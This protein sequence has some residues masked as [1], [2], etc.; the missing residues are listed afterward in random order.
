[1]ATKNSSSIV[2]RVLVVG[3]GPGG[4][5]AAISLKQSGIKEV[6]LADASSEGGILGSELMMQNPALRALERLGVAQ[7]CVEVGA[8]LDNYYFFDAM[9]NPIGEEATPPVVTGPHLPSLLG[10]SRP[11]IHKVL[12]DRARAL[13]CEIRYDQKLVGIAQDEHRVTAMFEN[14]EQGT[15]DLLVGADGVNST[16]RSL[17]APDAPKP[18]YV[19]EVA[20]RAWVPRFDRASL[21]LYLGKDKKVG[22]IAVSDSDAYLFMLEVTADYQPINREDGPRM[23]REKLSEFGGGVP[24]VRDA[25]QDP[26]RVHYTPLCPIIVPPFWHRGRVVMIGDAVHATTPHLANGAALAIEDGLVLGEELADATDLE[27]TLRQFSNRRYYR[28]RRI[29]EDGIQIAKWEIDGMVPGANPVGLTKMASS[30]LAAE[31]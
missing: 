21:E 10:I 13:G 5:A 19:G 31:I 25:I 16:V 24:Q 4:L 18:E 12:S 29:V 20:W 2:S 15:F 30:A 27:A 22:I 3:G 28:C 11:A 8:P 26:A 1:M 7:Q 6:I 17:V 14:G 23:L 9:G